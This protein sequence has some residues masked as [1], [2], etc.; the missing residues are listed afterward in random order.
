MPPVGCYLLP[1]TR[2]SIF[3]FVFTHNAMCYLLSLQHVCARVHSRHIVLP[4]ACYTCCPLHPLPATPATRTRG[5]PYLHLLPPTFASL[6]CPHGHCYRP[7]RHCYRT[8]IRII[9]TPILVSLPHQYLHQPLHPS[10]CLGQHRLTYFGT[11]SP[12]PLSTSRLRVHRHVLQL[13]T[14]LFLTTSVTRRLEH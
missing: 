5:L 13:P 12:E 4:A 3:A 2:Y 10:P 11:R 14:L 9:T 8:H 7:H 1:A 6:P